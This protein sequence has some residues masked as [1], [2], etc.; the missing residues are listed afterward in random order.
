MGRLYFVEEDTGKLSVL[1]FPVGHRWRQRAA[2]SPAW[3]EALPRDA[4]KFIQ[5][6]PRT[7][8][9]AFCA[10]QT[11]KP[12]SVLT[13]IYL[14]PQLPT[15]SSRLLGTAGPAEFPSTALLRDRV[16]SVKPMSPWAGCALTAPFHPYFADLREITFPIPQAE[17]AA[18][19]AKPPLPIETQFRWD[20]K[21]G[22]RYLSVAL[23]LGSPPAGVTRYPCP[24]EPGLSSSAAF[25]RASAAVRP[26]RGNI[27][28]H[29]N[30]IVKYLANSF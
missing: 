27:V 30:G 14:A 17:L 5:K 10:T 15:G 7:I 4:E 16:C 28:P 22:K 13:A 26:G 25:R 20:P 6:A 29:R 1:R 18:H 11:C 21:R 24:V 8:R 23:V 19:F 9:G 3:H 12:G 2:V